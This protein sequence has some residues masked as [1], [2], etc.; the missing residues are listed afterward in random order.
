MGGVL[1]IVPPIMVQGQ[2]NLL[3]NPSFDSWA[4]PN[5]IHSWSMNIDGNNNI[6]QETTM[7]LA[8]SSSVRFEKDNSSEIAR[9]TQSR[10]GMNL[11][12]T[13]TFS[14]WIYD[15]NPHAY[16][17]VYF[18]FLNVNEGWIDSSDSAEWQQ[19]SMTFVA[20]GTTA[21]IDLQL[22][23]QGGTPG[24]NLYADAA[25]LNQGNT[26]IDTI[27]PPLSIISPTNSTYTTSDIWLNYTLNPLDLP[28]W[29]AY[30]L[31]GSPN[32]TITENTTL[33]DLSEGPHVVLMWMNDSE[34]NIGPTLPIWFT[35]DTIAP[36]ITILSPS[37]VTYMTGSIGFFMMVD[38]IS[39]SWIGYSLDDE[40]NITYTGDI[41]LDGMIEG[42]HRLI[43]YA[44][45]S[46]GN[47]GISEVRFTVEFP[48]TSTT[49]PPPT[50]SIIYSTSVIIE[51]LT[52]WVTQSKNTAEFATLAIFAGFIGVLSLK[53]RKRK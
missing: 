19:I 41:L 24:G 30:S 33:T 27:P 32:V 44:N 47:M 23:N 48:S 4:N 16:I 31:D 43:V 35:I 12:E 22:F 9:L 6:T 28:S 52:T 18:G 42:S 45:D 36:V 2:T 25:A 11:S 53:R 51:T 46:F 8:G 20:D 34:G 1:L 50:T 49:I 21:Y 38:E 10:S 26:P 5:S 37:N 40:D 29:S 14:I 7:V 39:P 15:N 17:T 13:Y 3:A